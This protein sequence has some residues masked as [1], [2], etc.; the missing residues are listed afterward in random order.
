MILPDFGGAIRA[1]AVFLLMPY[2]RLHASPARRAFRKICVALFL[3]FVLAWMVIALSAVVLSSHAAPPPG[4]SGQYHDWYSKLLQPD[5]GMSCCSISDCRHE[6]W[7][8][9]SDGYDVFI[10]GEWVRIPDDKILK[11]TDNPT[12]EAVTCHAGKTIFC[13]IRPVES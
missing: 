12:G 5:T 7:R 2:Y 10:D 3:A 13:F 9:T 6:P 11:R 1:A 4:S 8:Q